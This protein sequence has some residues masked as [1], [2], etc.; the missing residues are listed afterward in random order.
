MA[1]SAEVVWVMKL[2][3][4]NSNCQR[5]KVSCEKK[6]ESNVWGGLELEAVNCAGF[7]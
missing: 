6:G 2:V 7:V 5:N 1:G 4:L 3:L